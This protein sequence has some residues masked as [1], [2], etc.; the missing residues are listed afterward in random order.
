MKVL[1]TGIGGRVGGK[2]TDLFLED[3]HQVVGFYRSRPPLLSAAEN[4]EIHQASLETL[5]A[6]LPSCDL[7]IH[8]A[9]HTPLSENQD[10]QYMLTNNVTATDLLARRAAEAGVKM[11]VFLSGISVYGEVKTQEVSEDTPVLRPGLYGLSKLMAEEC[12]KSHADP[13]RILCLRLPGILSEGDFRPWLGRTFLKLLKNEPVEIYNPKSLFNNLIT[14][15]ELHRLIMCFQETPGEAFDICNA[16]AKDPLILQEIVNLLKE[17][18]SSSSPIRTHEAARNSF[19]ID[20]QKLRAR[21][22]IDPASTRDCLEQL[23]RYPRP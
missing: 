18:L 17:G 12:L 22:Q 9:A 11:F 23:L 6:P 15:E 3:G 2:L 19:T 10:P 20:V 14:V 1:V 7:V 21:Y 5:A 13:M 8:A 16:A 4:L